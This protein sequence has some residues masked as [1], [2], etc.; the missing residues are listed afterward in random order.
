M[1]SF[2]ESA[3]FDLGDGN[4]FMFVN[5]LI[6]DVSLNNSDA[7]VQ[8]IIKTRNFPGQ[9]LTTNSTNTVTSTTEQSF[10]RVRTRQ[11]VG[12]IESNTADVAWTLGD[13][14]LDIRKDGRR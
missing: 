2:I 14:R 12:R 1:T 9:S 3:D 10:L 13:L 5:R 4:E 8:Y 11:A 6:P 7:S